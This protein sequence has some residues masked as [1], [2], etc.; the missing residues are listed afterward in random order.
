MTFSN[1]SGQQIGKPVEVSL[2]HPVKLSLPIGGVTQLG[3]TC[4]GRD[5]R[6]SEVANGFKVT[7]GDAGDY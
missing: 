6:T 2:G 3:L 1:E 7:L 4:N 5:R